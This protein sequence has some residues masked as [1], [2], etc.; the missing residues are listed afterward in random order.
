MFIIFI[1][2][3]TVLTFVLSILW[4]NTTL[5]FIAG[6]GIGASIMMTIRKFK[7]D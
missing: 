5:A 4:H 1:Y 7:N 3:L 2:I 6:Y